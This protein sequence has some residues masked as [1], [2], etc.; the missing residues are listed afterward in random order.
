MT[1]LELIKP[2]SVLC[3]AHARSKKHSLEILSELLSRQVPE[4]PHEEIFAKLVER[5][6][7]GSTCIGKGTAFPHCRIPNLAT[8]HG[9]L[10]KLS[11]PVDFD[12]TDGEFVDIVFGLVVPEELDDS[13][14]A[15]V[16][17]ITTLLDDEE[18]RTRLRRSASS[19]ELFKA[20][21]NGESTAAAE[22]LGEG[23]GQKQEQ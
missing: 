2:D 3:N 23:R 21:V 12:S 18:L 19:S 7:L 4:I 14:R 5:E 6:R 15:N 8:S 11:S 17:F 1:L 16:S 13:Q 9:A 20:M 10:M 22:E